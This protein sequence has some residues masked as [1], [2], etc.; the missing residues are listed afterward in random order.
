VEEDL[1]MPV[2]NRKIVAPSELPAALAAA[3]DGPIGASLRSGRN[4]AILLGN[5]AQQH[6]AA[7][8]IHALAQQ[9]ADAVTAKLGFLGE[10][11]NSVGGY[12]AGLPAGGNLSSILKKKAFLLLNAEPELDCADPHTALAALRKA[13]FVVA[14]SAFRHRAT[15]YAHVLLPIA[16]F[17]ETAGAYV[18]TEGRVQ[19]FHAAVRPA[20]EARPAWKVLRVLAGLLG[21]SG[22]EYDTI[23]QV[24]EECLR[25]KDPAALL[26]NRTRVAVAKPVIPVT[27]LKRI[28]D[29]PIY[30]A[31]ALV[32]RAP[33]LQRTKDARP[34]RCWM[35]ARLMQSI[36]VASGQPVLVRQGDGE[37][38]LD[39]ALDEKLPDGC[40]RVAAGHPATSGL[41]AMFG[42]L[43]V[44]KVDLERAA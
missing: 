13:H 23:E 19:R 27:G 41:G 1:L 24:R 18:S 28:A 35:N 37:A 22:F 12:L 29:V 7:A 4:S 8:Q 20:G 17:T 44:A 2:A 30:S 10:A 11:A 43:S 26:S 32:R 31:D 38:Q 25:G 34:P 21:V 16:P 9:L 3:G 42:T 33:S 40:V 36:G 5:F 39:A 6:P 14:L 15:E